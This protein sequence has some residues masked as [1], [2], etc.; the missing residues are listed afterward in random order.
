M[1][2]SASATS[3]STVVERTE[4]CRMVDI[5][6]DDLP[7][8]PG[9]LKALGR[10]RELCLGVYAERAHPRPDRSRRSTSRVVKDSRA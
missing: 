3:S 7:R 10:E 4:R 9:W 5:A 6:Q 8:Q 1:A 2:S